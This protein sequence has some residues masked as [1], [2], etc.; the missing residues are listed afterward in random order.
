MPFAERSQSPAGVFDLR[1]LTFRPAKQGVEILAWQDCFG[2]IEPQ[3][4]V[5]PMIGALI[6]QVRIIDIGA[7]DDYGSIVEYHEL[8]MVAHQV[9]A[10]V[11]RVEDAMLCA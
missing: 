10:A 11:A 3:P 5:A 4:Q 8:L 6:S 2:P 9:V 7:A 1:A